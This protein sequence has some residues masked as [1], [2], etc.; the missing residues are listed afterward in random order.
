[1]GPR[2]SADKIITIFSEGEKHKRQ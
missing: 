1:M 2:Y